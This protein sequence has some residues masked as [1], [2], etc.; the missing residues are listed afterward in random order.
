[1]SSK[2]QGLPDGELRE[3][4]IDFGL[5]YALIGSVN[6]SGSFSGRETCH[7]PPKIRMHSFHPALVRHK[8]HALKFSLTEYLYEVS[9]VAASYNSLF[10]EKDKTY[11][12]LTLVIDI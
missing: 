5:I 6:Q 1:M 3:M 8:P 9:V 2:I 11:S 4:N 7:L 12:L 10:G